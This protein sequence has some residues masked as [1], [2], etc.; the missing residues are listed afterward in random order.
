MSPRSESMNKRMHAFGG[1]I[2]GFL[3]VRLIY[4]LSAVGLS[5]GDSSTVHIYT[6]TVHRTTQL[7]WE[8]CRPCPVLGKGKKI[9][10]RTV[11]EDPDRE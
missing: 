5:P 8:E 7:I 2:A 6:K 4:L 9:H 3:N 1:R 10:R 11:H